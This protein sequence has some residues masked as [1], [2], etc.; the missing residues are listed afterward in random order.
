M[1]NSDSKPERMEDSLEE[2]NK[3]NALDVLKQQQN[4]V[5]ESSATPSQLL[6]HYAGEGDVERCRQLIKEEADVNFVDVG[7]TIPEG[8]SIDD[9]EYVHLIITNDTPMH[10]A[11]QQG[12]VQVADLLFYSQAKL[13]AKDKLG[14]TPLHRA[15]SSGHLD[16]VHALLKWDAD[17]GARNHIG[18]TALHIAAYLGNVEM[19]QLLLEHGAQRF[20]SSPN[21][22]EMTPTD[23]ARKKAIQTLLGGASIG[24]SRPSTA[25][26]RSTSIAEDSIPEEQEEKESTV[27][28]TLP[29]PSRTAAARSSD[30]SNML[31]IWMDEPKPSVQGLEQA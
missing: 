28:P 18:N 23:Y 14:S 5:D 9:P 16:M 22:V 31:R 24:S 2:E 15:V 29:S 4:G 20:A 1:G 25:V 12:H 13:E 11:A 8:K 10:R 7:P 3:T 6:L 19:V 26:S 27:A 30:S 21:R 17:I